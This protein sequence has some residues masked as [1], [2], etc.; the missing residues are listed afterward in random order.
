MTN[1]EELSLAEGV[2]C[3][4]YT[5]GFQSVGSAP[6]GERDKMVR[7]YGMLC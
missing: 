2:A 4:N 7:G 1:W 5:S 3:C 6:L